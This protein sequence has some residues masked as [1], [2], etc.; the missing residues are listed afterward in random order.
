MVAELKE[1]RYYGKFNNQVQ[2]NLRITPTQDK[3]IE[4]IAEV[5]D[6]SK[7]NVVREAIQF[8]YGYLKNQGVL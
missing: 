5:F 7:A 3:C 2:L 8:Y 1:R 4:Q 6:K